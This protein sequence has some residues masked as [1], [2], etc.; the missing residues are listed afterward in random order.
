[1]MRVNFYQ[2][3]HV[4]TLRSQHRCAAD[5]LVTPLLAGRL[6]LRDRFVELHRLLLAT[7]KEDRFA[8]G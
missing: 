3:V 7:V 4:E 1:M 8:A 2:P 6:A 5:S